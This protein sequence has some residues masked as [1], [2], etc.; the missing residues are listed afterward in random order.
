MG[1]RCGT[2][3]VGAL[4]ILSVALSFAGACSSGSG[5]SSSAFAD[6]W[7]DG[8]DLCGFYGG[9]GL[10][11][12]PTCLAGWPTA[13]DTNAALA[14]G[15][16]SR[17]RVASCDA[18]VRL[19]DKCVLAQ[20]C[21][22]YRE[23]NACPAQQMAFNTECALLL[24]AFDTYYMTHPRS[25]FVGSFHGSFSGDASGTFAGTL[26]ADGKVVAT[27]DND[28]AGTFSGTGTVLLSGSFLLTGS[29]DGGGGTLTFTGDLSGFTADFTGEG[30][31]TAG[32]ESGTWTL[33]SD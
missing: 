33:A 16:V 1:K 15:G 11:D 13:A 7:A 14:E 30:T 12:E 2:R 29:L 4:A 24:S 26:S 6:Y 20:S 10:V 21:E 5:S 18:A 32:D 19:L 23:G 28:T 31:W 22:S 27:I 25:V 8:H 17:D 3:R 9:C